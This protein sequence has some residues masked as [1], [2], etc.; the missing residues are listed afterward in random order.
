MLI[1]ISYLK[2]NLLGLLS[3]VFELTHSGLQSSRKQIC[4][5]TVIKAFVKTAK[6]IIKR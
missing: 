1:Y 6:I 5:K 4:N 2:Q 3:A